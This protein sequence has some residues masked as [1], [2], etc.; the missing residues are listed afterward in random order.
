MN[1]FCCL[2]FHRVSNPPGTTPGRGIVDSGSYFAG[3]QSGTDLPLPESRND[4]F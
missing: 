2:D 1:L 3:R 4:R